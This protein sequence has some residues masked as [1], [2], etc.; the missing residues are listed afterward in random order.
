MKT[1]AQKTNARSSEKTAASKAPDSRPNPQGIEMMRQLLGQGTIAAKLKIGSPSDLTERQ[2]DRVADAVVNGKNFAGQ[3]ENYHA[4]VA[5]K[6]HSVET[7]DF[8]S[9]ANG[10][11]A[12]SLNAL[13]SNYFESRFNLDF[14]HVWIHESP[15]AAKGASSINARAFTHGSDIYLNYGEYNFSSQRGKR[16]LAHELAHVVQQGNKP[17]IQRKK[18]SLED[19]LDQELQAWALKKGKAWAKEGQAPDT[20]HEDYIYDLKDYA[21][22]LISENYMNPKPVPKS[23]KGKKKWKRNFKK[24]EV[25]VKKI[26]ASGAKKQDKEDLAQI[27]LNIMAR[28]GFADVAFKFGQK[29]KKPDYIYTVI[30][31]QPKKAAPE[32][33]TEIT[34]YF[35]KKSGKKNPVIKK[36]TDATDA[37]EKN[38]S[39]DQ[40]T[41]ILE[42][43]MDKYKHDNIIYDIVSEV[44]IFR[45]RYRKFFSKWMWENSKGHL[46]FKIL[47]SKYFIEPG[48]RPTVLGSQKNALTLKKDMKWVYANKQKF[49]VNYLVKLGKHTT[50]K[51]K[52]PKNMK[53]KTLRKWLETHTEDIGKALAIQYPNRPEFWIKVYEQLTDIFFYHTSKNVKASRKGKVKGLGKDAPNRMRLKAD[54]DV[55]ATYAMRFF[56]SIKDPSNANLKVFEPIGYLLLHPEN[57]VGHAVA[58]MRRNGTYY[59][60]NNKQVFKTKIK[61]K[62]KDGKKETA[63]KTLRDNALDIYNT[64]PDQ[65]QVYYD[66]AEATGAMSKDL[67]KQKE[68]TRR[69]DLE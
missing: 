45:K 42:P 14:S 6:T 10:G 64:T 69:E 3:A 63:L 31:S 27:V 19:E 56:A 16:L 59:I 20:D 17:I 67:Y 38:L 28:A 13:E 54:C 1:V 50:V 18:K 32:T 39:H 60:I 62:T 12:R 23:R 37:F 53:F 48:Y 29:M 57:R 21:C 49:Y 33:L 8:L 43:L 30:L 58:L 46:L 15:E 36:L 11:G 2:A 7:D 26:L 66:D 51:I 34:K 44:L 40:L 52:K 41:A 25:L 65:Y 4:P 22:K 55:L 47:E 61:E 35:I 9:K 24:A 68:T 5:A